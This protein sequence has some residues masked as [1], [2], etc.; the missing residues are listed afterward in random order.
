MFLQIDDVR[1]F[2][3]YRPVLIFTLQINTGLLFV[4]A[5]VGDEQK[6]IFFQKHITMI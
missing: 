4:P 5:E 3:K 2:K 1:L 6:K